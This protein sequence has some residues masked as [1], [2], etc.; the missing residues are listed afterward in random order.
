MVM[1]S[2]S[3][4]LSF[5]CWLEEADSTSAAMVS[6][7]HVWDDTVNAPS[8]GRVSMWQAPPVLQSPP[9]KWTGA[10]VRK[11]TWV[12]LVFTSL[13]IQSKTVS[14]DLRYAPSTVIFILISVP[15]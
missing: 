3:I 7:G 13:L 11:N 9:L 10:K 15:T 1:F 6:L 12:L 4:S 14:S 5:G 8:S 2:T